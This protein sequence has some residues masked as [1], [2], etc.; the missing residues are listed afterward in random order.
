MHAS[1]V[2]SCAA[3][4]ANKQELRRAS[5]L[6]GTGAAA[7]LFSICE[8]YMFNP[9]LCCSETMALTQGQGY[10]SHCGYPL[11]K[12]THLWYFNSI[13]LGPGVIFF[14]QLSKGRSGV[15]SDWR[16]NWDWGMSG[17]MHRDKKWHQQSHL[18]VWVWANRSVRRAI[19][20]FALLLYFTIKV[21]FTLWRTIIEPLK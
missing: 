13:W 5:S 3:S 6:K 4:H 11:W 17:N 8:M 16:G 14:Q 10:V 18:S 9:G 21:I 2:M 20:V 7:S 15:C 12:H 19:C 1:P